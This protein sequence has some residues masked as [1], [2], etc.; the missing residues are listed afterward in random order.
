MGLVG[1][2]VTTSRVDIRD[3]IMNKEDIN[4]L[5]QEIDNEDIGTNYNAPE[6]TTMKVKDRGRGRSIM[7]EMNESPLVND[8]RLEEQAQGF[9]M[10]DESDNNDQHYKYDDRNDQD[11]MLF[12]DDNEEKD[13]FQNQLN[14]DEKQDFNI[15][16]HHVQTTGIKDN[17]NSHI[18]YGLDDLMDD[19]SEPSKGE[20]QIQINPMNDGIQGEQVDDLLAEFDW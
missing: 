7:R 11:M 17:D 12:N 9:N 6:P 5:L 15:D 20:N 10:D 4:D 1:T 3:D 2:N 8:R 18:Q 13:N 19:D 14:Y 16:N